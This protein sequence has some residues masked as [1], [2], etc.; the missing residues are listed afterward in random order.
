MTQY[1]QYAHDIVNEKINACQ[2]VKNA[3]RRFLNDLNRTDLIFR[4]DIIDRILKFC[5]CLK[6]FRG[7]KGIVNQ[8]IVFESF[9]QF[10]IANIFGFY[11]LDG[12]R[13]FKTSYIEVA[14]KNAKTELMSSL[15]MYA[16]LEVPAAQIML[17][18]NSRE[19]A[20]IAFEFCRYFARDLDPAKEY[21][22]IYRDRIK[23]ND[24][25][26][27]VLVCSSDSGKYDG[28]QPYL[29][30]VDEFHESKGNGDCRNVMLSGMIHPLSHLTTITTAGFNM[31][32]PCYQLR[33]VC[34]DILA[35]VKE[36]DRMFTIIYGLDPGDDWSDEKNWI[37]CS[38]NI[39]KSAP[40]DVYR[41]ECQGAKN[42]PSEELNFRTKRCNEWVA[43][44]DNWIPD[45]FINNVRKKM[46]FEDFRG[47]S[48]YV[49]VDLASVSD[50][51][52]VSYCFRVDDKYK[53]ITEYYLPESALVY[54][55]NKDM[56]RQWY[57]QGFLNVTPGNTTDYT[58]IT[59]DM[60]RKQAEYNIF[61][62]KVAY[63]PY[64]AV[65]WAI[66]SVEAGLDLEEFSQTVFNFN[67]GTRELERLILSEQAELEMNEITA[68]CFR[69]VTLM[70][71]SNNNCKPK[72]K[73]TEINKIDGVIAI[74]EALATAIA[75]PEISG[76]LVSF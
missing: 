73:G 37:K 1:E 43:V 20:A 57:R 3:C 45:A 65:Q 35:G 47:M 56:Y 14:R 44:L 39:G 26:A 34:V 52:A 29:S 2:H 18:A 31:D 51:T 55:S 62:V 75:Y 63:D 21:L 74:V 19:Q 4:R 10:I 64:N 67:R 6:H 72:K 17:V 8:P 24:T 69:N 13:R 12:R 11:Y 70:F 41:A 76:D 16:M 9:Q 60:L 49:G 71:D 22:K 61:I 66:D 27:F 68:Y 42:N 36:D 48:C 40:L 54:G 23:L 30:I 28:Y 15:A 53:F 5:R 32:G 59:Q 38:P 33:Q 46:S 7:P 25:G 58:Y 50:L